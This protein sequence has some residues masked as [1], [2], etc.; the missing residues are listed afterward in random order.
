MFTE[1][2]SDAYGKFALL[3]GKI[4]EYT[5]KTLLEQRIWLWNHTSQ[6]KVYFNE[7]VANA[8]LDKIE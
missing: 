5:R 8:L 2:Y 3:R 4:C 7:F 1:S 6:T